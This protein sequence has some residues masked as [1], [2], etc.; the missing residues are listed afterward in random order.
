M[1]GL[2][3]MKSVKNAKGFTLIELMIVVAIVG[4]LAAVALPAY[5]NYTDKAK[6]SEVIQ[7]A[8]LYKTAA[9]I[10]AQTKATAKANLTAGSAGIPA[11]TTDANGE[12]VG[13]VSITAGLITATGAGGN[14]AGVTYTLDATI[15]A[16]TG[17][18]TWTQGGTCVAKGLC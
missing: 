10:S 5:Q 12:H 11:A 6:Y 2:N 15:D 14:L 3:S 8:T 17:A 16:S 1:K 13:A 7:A 4:I 18:V 9:E